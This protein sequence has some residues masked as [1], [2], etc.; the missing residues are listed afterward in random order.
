VTQKAIEKK[1]VRPIEVA[2]EL[3][4]GARL[5][6]G[7][8]REELGQLEGRVERRNIYWWAGDISTSDR[9]KVDWV[10]EAAPGSR[11]GVVARHERA[12]TARAELVL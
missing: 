1:A 8:E 5:I 6:T 7:K 3:P 10:V 12:G 11:I 2:L 4:A 9:T